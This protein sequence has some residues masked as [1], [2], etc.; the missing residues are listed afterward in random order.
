MRFKP[1]VID[2]F[3]YVTLHIMLAYY[4]YYAL[5]HGS[6]HHYKVKRCLFA[7]LLT[8]HLI[9]ELCDNARSHWYHSFVCALMRVIR[10]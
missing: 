6:R 5:L 8:M 7:T 1:A 4:A 10:N 9:M 3:K 2:F